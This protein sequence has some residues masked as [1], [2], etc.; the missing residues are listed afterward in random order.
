[1]K[2]V[3]VTNVLIHLIRNSSTWQ[4]IA[5]KHNPFDK[6]NQVFIS[7]VSVA[8][9]LS[10]AKQVGW[11]NEKMKHLASSF[12]EMEIVTVSGNADDLLIQAYVE[13]DSYS[14]GKNPQIP[15]P[16]GISSRNMS[17]NDIWIASTAY[18]LQAKLITT[19]KDFE[20]LDK[21]FVD[22]FLIVQK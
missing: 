22:I 17:K 3:F 15:L 20:H 8:E 9:I 4:E 7:F 2:Y 14:Q 16:K 21:V 11:G 18:A 10:I 6:S 5:K 13:I 12:S 1:M 19:D